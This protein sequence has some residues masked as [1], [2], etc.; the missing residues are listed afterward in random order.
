MQGDDEGPG[1]RGGGV[2]SSMDGYLGFPGGM[3]FHARYG[4]CFVGAGWTLT[5]VHSQF[6]LGSFTAQ[7]GLGNAVSDLELGGRKGRRGTGEGR[8]G[9][10]DGNAAGLEDSCV[11][12]DPRGWDK[13]V[14][15]GL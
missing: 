9:W 8:V 13:W 3:L 14:D 4:A 7:S 5:R 1:A 10:E 6:V 12:D 11:G 2:F 15:E